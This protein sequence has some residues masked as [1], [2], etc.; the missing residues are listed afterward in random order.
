[1]A[2]PPIRTHHLAVAHANRPHTA[3]RRSGAGIAADTS[4]PQSRRRQHGRRDQISV[5]PSTVDAGIAF[6]YYRAA[7]TATVAAPVIT[8]LAL[9]SRIDPKL[10]RLRHWVQRHHV[11]ATATTLIIIG[12]TILL[13]GLS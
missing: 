13:Y 6:T 7:A 10:E 9:G 2:T 12:V 4:Q 11:A 3:A 5:L 8:Y 1:M